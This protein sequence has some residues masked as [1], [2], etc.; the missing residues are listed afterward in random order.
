MPDDDND[1][2]ID[3]LKSKVNKRKVIKKARR[4][5][6]VTVRHAKRFLVK[7]WSNL[8]EVRRNVIT[9]ILLV[10]VLIGATGLQWMW[11][12]QTYRTVAPA[13]NTT[14]VEGVMGPVNTLNPLY[15][16]T[17]A[18]KSASKL[19]F[20][21]LLKYDSSG[22]LSYDLADNLSVDAKGTTYTVKIKSN[23]KWSDGQPLTADDVV[24]TVKLIQ[25]NSTR[26]VISGWNGVTAKAIDGT[27]VEFSLP[28]SYSAFEHALTFA[29]LP[30]HILNNVS[31]SQLRE[32]SFSQTPVGSGPF[33]IN[34][35]QNV[36]TATGEKIVYLTR[37][38]NYYNGLAKVSTF[39]LHAYPNTTAIL[40]ALSK[41]AVNAATDLTPADA[42]QIDNSKYNVFSVPVQSGVYA[43]LNTQS[44]FLSD[45][46]VRKALQLATDTKAIRSKLPSGTNAL[47]SPFTSSQLSESLPAAPDY[48]VAGAKN[49][50]EQSGWKLNKN[51][52]REKDGKVLKISV[53]TTKSNEYEDV[54]ET[55]AGQW[56]AIGVSVDTEVFDTT[57]TTQDLTKNILQPRAYDVLL[58]K[59]D[60][61]ADPD[62]YAY[63]HSSQVSTEGLNLANYSS[64]VS[65][66]ILASARLTLDSSLRNAKYITFAK[67]WL[68]DV[69]AIGLYQSTMQYASGKNVTTFSKD[70]HIVTAVDRYNQVLDWSSSMDTIYKTP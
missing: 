52:L 3:A 68:S 16:T 45:V 4:I 31:S 62:M 14:Y 29:I 67:K 57:D 66:D 27:T 11:C 17:S 9:W 36:D 8:L 24:F 50:L 20:S 70:D 61:G 53:V 35:I 32:N 49:I 41:N 10:A 46:N 2:K 51:G 22:H 34:F 59:L 48:D 33:K 1:S 28:N 5:E 47:Y 56:R 65:D 43:I 44:E 21:S 60:M 63:W 64:S 6:T 55:L 42:A 39:E 26:S 30:K 12:Q 7:R 69:P 25:D 58:Y 18:E 13:E 40:S 37:N 23:A 54:L 38:D 15:A 19:L